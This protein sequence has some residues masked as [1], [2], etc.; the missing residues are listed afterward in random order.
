MTTTATWTTA[1]IPAYRLEPGDRTYLFGPAG[2]P[3]GVSETTIV[4]CDVEYDVVTL[5]LDTGVTLEGT[6]RQLVTVHVPDV[7][8]DG[9]NLFKPPATFWPSGCTCLHRRHPD[10]PGNWAIIYTDPDC[11]SHG[12]GDEWED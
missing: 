3:A 10:L 8:V 2:R 11:R 4:R 9:Y 12:I 1:E 6:A 5:L 7:P